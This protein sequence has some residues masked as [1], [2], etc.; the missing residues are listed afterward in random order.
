MSVARRITGHY[1]SMLFRHRFTT[2]APMSDRLD[3]LWV[4]PDEPTSTE[5][6]G[7]T[8]RS[9]FH[10]EELDRDAWYFAPPRVHSPS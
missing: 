8:L 6:I 9:V 2:A 10:I 3:R 1:C 5:M 4:V 7:L